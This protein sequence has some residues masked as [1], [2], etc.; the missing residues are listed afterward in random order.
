MEN[1]QGFLVAKQTHKYALLN[2]KDSE[3]FNGMMGVSLLNTEESRM[4]QRFFYDNGCIV[5]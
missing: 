3:L 2:T 5:G 4:Q 1:I